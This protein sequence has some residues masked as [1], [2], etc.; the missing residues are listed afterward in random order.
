MRAASQQDVPSYPRQAFASP[1]APRDPKNDDTTR[2]GLG[3]TALVIYV[4]NIVHISRCFV[5][6]GQLSDST[7]YGKKKHS[8]TKRMLLLRPNSWIFVSTYLNCFRAFWFPTDIN[9]MF[10][11]SVFA[12]ASRPVCRIFSHRPSR[13]HREWHLNARAANF[14]LTR[15]ADCNYQRPGYP[16]HRFPWSE[17]LRCISNLNFTHTDTHL[18]IFKELFCCRFN[19]ISL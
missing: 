4:H 17:A 15:R 7:T 3:D 13:L 14:D 10:S 6:R 1:I 18:S 11:L 2:W 9:S 19:C 8:C 12:K 16:K 5:V